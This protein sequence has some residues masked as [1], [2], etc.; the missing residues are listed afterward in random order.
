[1]VLA[2]NQWR[3]RMCCLNEKKG[4][5]ILGC[6]CCCAAFAWEIK[7]HLPFRVWYNR[8]ID[9]VTLVVVMLSA[10]R[11]GHWDDDVVVLVTTMPLEFLWRDYFDC[12]WFTPCLRQPRKVFEVLGNRTPV[13]LGIF[14]FKKDRHDIRQE[15]YA[16]KIRTWIHM[17]FTFDERDVVIDVYETCVGVRFFPLPLGL[18]CTRKTWWRQNNMWRH[19]Q[20]RWLRIYCLYSINECEI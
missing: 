15:E 18:K 5:C 16:V 3:K 7:Y 20:N 17:R 19:K 6:G 14:C 8:L 1:M 2:L 4:V 11:G 13:S 10:R 12:W 9:E